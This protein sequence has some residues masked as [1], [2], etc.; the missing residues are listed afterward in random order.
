MN[1]LALA[2]LAVAA[3]TGHQGAVAALFNNLTGFEHD[4]AVRGLDG[5]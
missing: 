2:E 3:T 1:Q 5:G 4:D